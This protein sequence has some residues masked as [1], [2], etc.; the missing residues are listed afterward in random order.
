MIL[1]KIVEGLDGTSA[2]ALRMTGDAGRFK[3]E[4]D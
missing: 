4:A 2:P 1:L 3:Y